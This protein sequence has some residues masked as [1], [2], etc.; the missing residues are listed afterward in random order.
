VERLNDVV[1]SDCHR[2]KIENALDKREYASCISS[3]AKC[4]SDL[5]DWL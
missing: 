4:M 5:H 1:G 3:C 2:E